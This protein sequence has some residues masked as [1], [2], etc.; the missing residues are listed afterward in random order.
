MKTAS[1]PLINL[2]RGHPHPDLL[3]A[4]QFRKATESTFA[5]PSLLL[6]GLNYGP[7]QGYE[8]LRKQLARWLTQFYKPNDSIGPDRICISGG[9]SQNLARIL[10]VFSDPTFTNVWIVSPT[11]F[12]ACRIFEDSGFHQLRAIPED[13]E[14]LDIGFL[15]EEL[16]K[17]DESLKYNGNPKPVREA[18]D[19]R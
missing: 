12:L 5:N 3:P 1:K 9:A 16:R 4:V 8:P 2:L 17:S 7:H 13:A 14:G 18:M 6:Q 10:Q 19:D 11:Y 15:Q